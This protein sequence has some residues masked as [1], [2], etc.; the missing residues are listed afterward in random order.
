MSFWHS[1]YNDHAPSVFSYLVGR[2]GREHAEDLLQET[3]VRA[4]RSSSLREPA[5]LRSYLLSTAHNLL[6]NRAR[7]HTP[8][9]FSDLAP[10]TAEVEGTDATGADARAQFSELNER[11]QGALDSMSADH[12]RAFEMG[13][14]QQM[15]YDEISE[16]TGWSRSLVKVNIHRARKK[17]I[18]HLGDYR[19]PT[20]DG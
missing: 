13:V 9:L 3:F 19:H 11:L 8:T 1:A 18:Q 12:R 7:K 15:P 2:V 17:A 14:L 16:E 4:I 6:I 20:M 5:K 10:G